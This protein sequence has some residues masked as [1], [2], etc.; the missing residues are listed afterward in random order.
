M[1][2]TGPLHS[3]SSLRPTAA[4]SPDLGR[5]RSRSGT[6]L[7]YSSP[8]AAC[9]PCSINL[10]ASPSEPTKAIAS[11]LPEFDPADA[12]AGRGLVER[13]TADAAALQQDVLTEI[14]TRN[15]HTEYLRRFL[16]GLPPGASAAD[17]REAFKERVP[18]VRYEDIKPYVYRIVSGEP[19]SV[20]CSERITDLV[21]R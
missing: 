6:R 15:A 16:D 13:L 19:S 18:V 2:V 1:F 11:L 8:S 5:R 7:G 3:L 4:L 10:A 9:P 21:R 17:L 20:L 14:L 12:G